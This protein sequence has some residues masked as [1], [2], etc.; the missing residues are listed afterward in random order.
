[1]RRRAAEQ[2]QVVGAAARCGSSPELHA[3]GAAASVSTLSL[4]HKTP[5]KKGTNKLKST[6][7]LDLEIEFV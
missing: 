2:L 5:S 6:N 4:I 1:M 7:K 3:M